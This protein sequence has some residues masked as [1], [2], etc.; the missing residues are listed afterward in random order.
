MVDTCNIN[1]VCGTGDWNGPKP[2][3]PNMNDLLLKATPAFGGIDIEFTW[4]TTNPGAVGTTRLF[5]STDANFAGATIRAFV[6]GNFYFDKTD[7]GSKV[8]QRYYYWIQLVSINGTDGEIIGPASATARPL[9]EQMIEQLTGEIDSGLLSQELRKEIAQIELNKLGITQEE[10]E[11][12]KNDDALGV[13]LTQIDA[14]MDQNT[15]ILQEEVRARVTADSS[16]VQTVNTMYADFNGNIAAIQQENT[17]LATKVNALASSV[18]T[19]NATVNGDSASG[20]VGLVAEVQTLDGKVTQIGARWTATVDVN[21]LV[22]GFGVYNDGRTVEAGFNVDRF[23]IGRPG[24]PKNPGSYP[25]II[26]NNIVYIKE[27]AIQKLTFDKLRAQDGSFIVQNGKIQADYIEAK[28]IV[29][30]NIQSDNYQ[31]GVQGW[32]FRPNGI[33]EIN[34]TAGTGRMT[35]NNATIK[36]FDQAGKLRVHIGNLQA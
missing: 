23:W 31:P 13:R 36:V 3:D 33:M 16:L 24:T 10:I 14:K 18:T 29:V 7:P 32:A 21:G 6:N 25:F 19:I 15:A 17:A 8:D 34:G 2:G 11:R 20:K 1:G 9:I 12:A 5:R 26:D 22:G 28:D 4:P 35:I 27:A 30:N